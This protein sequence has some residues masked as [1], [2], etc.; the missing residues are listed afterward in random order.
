MI[1]V[2]IKVENVSIG[3]IHTY[4]LVDPR[5]GTFLIMHSTF[6][7]ERKLLRHIIYILGLQM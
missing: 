4:F 1:G 7:V 3:G 5:E 6:L 2:F